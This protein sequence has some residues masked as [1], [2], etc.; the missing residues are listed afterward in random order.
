M[1]NPKR[2]IQALVTSLSQKFPVAFQRNNQLKTFGP[3]FVNSLSVNK[4]FM[5]TLNNTELRQRLYSYSNQV[6]FDTQKDSFREVISFLI[7]IDQNFLYTLLNPEEIRYLATHRDD[8]ER[9]KRQLIQVV[10]S[11]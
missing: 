8:E 5:K 11:L 7:D 2:V 10:E 9:L 1:T 4:N 6:G 3:T